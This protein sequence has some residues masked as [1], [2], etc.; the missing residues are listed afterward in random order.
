M[1]KTEIIKGISPSLDTVAADAVMKTKFTPGRI[2]GNPVKTQVAV[3][4]VFELH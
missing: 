1:V 4:I 2:S 3:P